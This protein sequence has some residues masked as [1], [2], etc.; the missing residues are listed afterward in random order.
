MILNNGEYFT[1]KE[2]SEILNLP[3][4]TVR[5]RLFRLGFKPVVAESIYSKTA[6]DA[7]KDIKL[8]RPI[9]NIKKK[10]KPADSVVLLPFFGK[11]AAGHPINIDNAPESTI[12][13]PASLI[14]G[15]SGLFYA[16]KVAGTSMT[17]AG[18]NDGDI[19]IIK[20]KKDIING[21][22]ALIRYHTESMLK[23]IK[24]FPD[25]ICLCWDDGSGKMITV[26]CED[27]EIQ[28]AFIG[29]LK[30]SN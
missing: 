24:V 25:K 17:N 15:Q 27:Y 14:K 11:V 13:I 12:P 28:G 5:N 29:V 4:N 3:I 23:R 8:G 18:I 16:V 21:S 30:P 1:L 10:E 6:F 7:I 9:T 26:D 22:I 19:A 20:H 2:M